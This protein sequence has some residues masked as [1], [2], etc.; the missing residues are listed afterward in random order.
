MKFVCATC[1]EE[2][3]AAEISFGADQ[4]NWIWPRHTGDFSLF[5]VYA[6]EFNNPAEARLLLKT[7]NE[8]WERSQPEPE[9]RRLHL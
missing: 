7:F 1:G 4:D 6:D 5:R 2:H 3:D 8:A 9:L